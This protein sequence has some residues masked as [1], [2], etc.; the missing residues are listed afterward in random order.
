[1]NLVCLRPQVQDQHNRR[2]EVRLQ[3]EEQVQGQEM[4]E[5]GSGDVPINNGRNLEN[6]NFKNDSI[7][8]VDNNGMDSLI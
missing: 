5:P 1:M 8:C 4:L 6:F 7:S 2:R 3:P